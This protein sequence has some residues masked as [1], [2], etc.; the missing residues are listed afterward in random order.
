M[1]LHAAKQHNEPTTA[2]KKKKKDSL[3]FV[4]SRHKRCKSP[5]GRPRKHHQ[6]TWTAGVWTA[7]ACSRKADS[8]NSAG[9]ARK[10]LVWKQK[11][12]PRA[13]GEMRHN[14][15][16]QAMPRT[17]LWGW[18]RSCC[19]PGLPLMKTQSWSRRMGLPAL[20]QSP[21]SSQRLSQL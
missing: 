1:C 21:W 16:L 3:S 18:T 15:L 10:G 4:Y 14:P 2:K 5:K 6:D 17:A 19:L 20:V 7:R 9:K 11:T 13:E 12:Q 8:D